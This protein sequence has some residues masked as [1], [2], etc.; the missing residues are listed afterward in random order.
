MKRRRF[1]QALAGSGLGTFLYGCGL[2]LVWSGPGRRP[3]RRALFV[4]HGLCVGCR[5]CEE[6]CQRVNSVEGRGPSSTTRSLIYVHSYLPGPYHVAWACPSC[7]DV[8]CVNAC[9]YYADPVRHQ[10]AWR[11]NEQT[12]G[13]ELE[14]AACAGCER[15]IDACRREGAGVLRWDAHDYVCGACHLCGGAPACVVVC[16]TQAISLQ[17]LDE[18]HHFPPRTPDEAAGQGIAALRREQQSPQTQVA[19]MPQRTLRVDADQCTGC[20]LC[21]AAC[22]ERNQQVHLAGQALPGTGDRARSLIRVHSFPGPYY[23]PWVCPGCPDVPC[24]AACR[25]ETFGEPYRRALHLDPG[26]GAVALRGTTCLYGPY[27]Q[28]GHQRVTTTTGSDHTLSIR[29]MSTE[30]KNRLSLNIHAS[31]PVYSGPS[32]VVCLVLYALG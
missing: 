24:V 16:P 1:V 12:G 3:G 25:L 10:R 31:C 30:L 19:Q 27:S 21:E 4:D 11:I 7:P 8:P 6:A 22:D 26:S 29:T 18:E 15:C 9:D 28:R 5:R 13:L 17:G 20:R 2:P 32:F 14:K 23:V